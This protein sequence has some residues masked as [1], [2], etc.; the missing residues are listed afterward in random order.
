MKSVFVVQHLHT[1]PDGED[2]VKMIGVY[3]TREDA[4]DAVR[5]L[6]S[7]P[8]FHN[9]PDVVDYD[10]DGDGQ[11]FHVEEYEIGKDHWQEGYVTD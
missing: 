1:L 4:V 11:G 5:R 6:A 8:G 9:L 3:A 10:L 7:Q 2:N